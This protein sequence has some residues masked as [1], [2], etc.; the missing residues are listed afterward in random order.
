MQLIVVH[1]AFYLDLLSRYKREVDP[2]DSLVSQDTTQGGWPPT[3]KTKTPL[4]KKRVK[5]KNSTFTDQHIL[6]HK[7]HEAND[8]TPINPNDHSQG[9]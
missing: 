4:E 8:V 7:P 2:A 5:I 3:H 1:T 6:L 9:T